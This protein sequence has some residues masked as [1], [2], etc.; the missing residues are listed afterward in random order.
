MT[1]PRRPSRPR[2]P[3]LSVLGFGVSLVALWVLAWGELTAA[4]VIS[5]VV[6]A[7]VLLVVFPI[8]TDVEQVTHRLRPLAVVRVLA[9]FLGELVMSTLGVAR[10][11]LTPHRPTRTGIVACPLRV[12]ADGLLT[13]LAG[14]ITLSPGTM[15][16]EVTHHPPVIY[17]HV[18][19]IADAD[20]VR[21]RVARFE[22]LA[23]QALGDAVALEAVRQ[24]WVW[25]PADSGEAP[26]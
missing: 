10:L 5:G 21:E 8:R 11:V 14:A 17:L 13:F 23:V 12:E 18:L 1:A 7:T 3:S 2:R 4:N 9:F 24:P 20:I 26:R 16:V 6:V 15:A 19:D 22:A 25:P